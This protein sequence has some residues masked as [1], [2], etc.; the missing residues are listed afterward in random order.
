MLIYYDRG[1]VIKKNYIEYLISTPINHTCKNLAK[2][3]EDVSHDAVNDYLYREKLTARHLWEQVSP[4]LNDSPAAHPIVDDSVKAKKYA[5]K[6]EIVKR[7]WS[8]N[9]GA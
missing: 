5:R 3:F 8:D 2:H 7:Q 4:L 6:M 1:M 9:E